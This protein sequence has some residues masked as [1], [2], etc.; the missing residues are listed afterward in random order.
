MNHE[1]RRFLGLMGVLSVLVVIIVIT[2]IDWTTNQ[3]YYPVTGTLMIDGKPGHKIQIHFHPLGGDAQICSGF[4]NQEGQFHLFSGVQGFP[5]AVPGKYCIVLTQ[6]PGSTLPIY[7]GED[8]KK[9]PN[10]PPHTFP[11]DYLEAST[12]PKEVEVLK[13]SNVFAIDI[14]M[15][16]GSVDPEKDAAE[17]RNRPMDPSEMYRRGNQSSMP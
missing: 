4:V 12:S 16:P 17:G 11:P 1:G 2:Q 15:P 3:K 8:A 7:R 9:I 13:K 5:G 14:T 10:M 6:T